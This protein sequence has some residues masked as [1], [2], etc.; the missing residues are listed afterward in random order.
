MRKISTAA[1]SIRAKSLRID[2]FEKILQKKASGQPIDFSENNILKHLY[3]QHGKRKELER[4]CSEIPQIWWCRMRVIYT[5]QTSRMLLPSYSISP[6][7]CHH[8]VH[9]L[10]E[11]MFEEILFH[12]TFWQGA[13]H[14][15]HTKRIFKKEFFFVQDS[16]SCPY[17]DLE[18]DCQNTN[19]EIDHL[20]PTSKFPLLWFYEH[21]LV[22]I[23]KS[24]NSPHSGKADK[25]AAIYPNLLHKEI[26]DEISYLVE[27]KLC[28]KSTCPDTDEFLR[29]INLNTRLDSDEMNGLMSFWKGK[30][31]SQ[32]KKFPGESLYLDRQA[33]LFFIK[34]EIY[35]LYEEKI[36]P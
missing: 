25:I 26:G 7:F 5:K 23:C 27:P 30:I 34:R 4:L 13:G 32:I 24:C 6:N 29:L 9:N 36:V 16:H 2:V 10:M 33:E 22:P 14:K 1:L 31:L 8:D 20:L 28:A 11:F 17:C 19:F 15:H 35:K 12:K 21:N 18:S 3:R